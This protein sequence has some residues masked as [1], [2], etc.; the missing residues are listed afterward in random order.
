MPPLPIRFDASGLV[1]VIVQDE[2]TG[3]VRMCAFATEEA[4]LATVETGRATF[5]SR[6]R[7]EIWEKG[8]TSGNTILVGRVLVDCDADCLIYAAEP[9]GP[10]CHTGE[11]T[12][13]FQ[14]L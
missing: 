2:L 10:S 9:Q 4:V 5:F 1:P 7:G 3:E 6:S 14:V 13:F 11:P 12:C 8:K